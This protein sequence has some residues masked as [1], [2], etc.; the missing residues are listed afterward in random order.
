LTTNEHVYFYT[1]DESTF[2]PTIENVMLNYS[3][4]SQMMIDKDGLYAVAYKP[5]Q[6]AFDIFSRKYYNDL[7]VQSISKNFEGCKAI[8][9]EKLNLVL[10]THED[11]LLWVDNKT[12]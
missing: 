6:K 12:Y 10:V 1:I 4:C 5:N 11:E 7:R 2:E 8:E 9:I 3:S